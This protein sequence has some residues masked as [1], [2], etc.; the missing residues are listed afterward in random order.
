MRTPPLWY[1][2][3]EHADGVRNPH[4]REHPRVAAM[5]PKEAG[6]YRTG[7]HI[8]V[9]GRDCPNPITTF[10]QGSFPAYVMQTLLAQ[11]YTEPTPVQAQAWPIA[12]KGR[13]IVGVAD[14]GSG[15]TLAFLLPAIV[16]INAQPLLEKGDG[17]IVLIMTPTR[18]LAC[19]IQQEATRYGSSCHIKN[20]C[21]YGGVPKGPQVKE[22]QQGAEI[23]VATPGRLIDILAAHKT[24]LRRVTYLTLDEADRMLDMGFEQHMHRI[25]AQIRPDRQTLMFTATW[26]EEIQ[27]IS[28]DFLVDPIKITIGSLQLHAVHTITQVVDVCQENE[29]PDKLQHL[30]E[31]I[32]DGGK[33]L[34]FSDTKRAADAL[35]RRLRTEGWPALSMHGDK[36]QEE[37]DWVL[38]EFKSGKT[39]ILI[40][41]DVAARGL[42]AS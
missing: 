27:R 28:N 40:A 17:P 2:F 13:D 19:Q 20:S 36:S 18:E 9:Q 3:L 42:G 21:L 8:T 6:E 30:L 23:V 37:R 32:M 7:R 41:T 5:T 15:K 14:T 22:L 34:I 35:T 12:L 38:N 4:C 39:P 11:E 25:A 29:K 1:R 24:N 16:H 26:P 10:E 31:R 33:I